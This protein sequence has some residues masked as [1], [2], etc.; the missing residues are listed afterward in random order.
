MRWTPRLLKTVDDWSSLVAEAKVVLISSLPKE[1][2]DRIVECA[3]TGFT[4]TV[5]P[6]N[7]PDDEKIEA[8]EDADFPLLHPGLISERVLRSASK[9]KLVQL[10]RIGHELVDLK[11]LR[12]LGIPFATSGNATAGVVADHTVMLML[13]VYRSL[14]L[15]DTGVKAGRWADLVDV[16]EA[17]EMEDKL[18]G[19]LGMGNIGR[20]VAQRLHGFGSRVQYFSRHRLPEK[21]ERDLSVRY[22]AF[23]KL[24]STSDIVTIHIPLTSEAEHLV[25]RDVLSLMKPSAV[26]INTSRGQV[27]DEVDLI[28]ALQHNRLFGA[29]LDV[30]EKQPPDP[31]NP[32]L[33]MDN[34]VLTP[35]NASVTVEKWSRIAEFAW[36]NVGA[37]WEGKPA[38]ALVIV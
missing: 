31:D 12:E 22:V 8:C 38:N 34:V 20:K 35:H 4:T 14:V 10:L 11:L 1:A 23:R 3:P 15:S 21:T 5:M 9:L 29:G 16:V 19:V 32:L 26:L 7:S 2:S 33:R 28:D 27:I 18:V 6:N 25:D 30:L 13:A 17:F 24:F 37:V 36:R